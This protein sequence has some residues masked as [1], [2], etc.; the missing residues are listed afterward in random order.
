[1]R[2]WRPTVVHSRPVLHGDLDAVVTC[3]ALSKVVILEVERGLREPVLVRDIV[4]RVRDV[5]RVDARGVDVGLQRLGILRRVLDVDE[6]EGRRRL[7]GRHPPCGDVDVGDGVVAAVNVGMPF[8]AGKTQIHWQGGEAER[9]RY[10][11]YWSS[12]RYASRTATRQCS[13]G[14]S[15]S[16]TLAG[17]SVW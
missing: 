10:W 8:R 16:Q 4:D 14:W 11:W 7:S 13:G 9:T 17:C 15:L 12:R 3:A 5:E 2:Q 6:V 1:M